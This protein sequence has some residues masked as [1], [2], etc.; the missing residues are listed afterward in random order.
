[1]VSI[2]VA[3]FVAHS[4]S[5]GFEV[6]QRV[7]RD[8]SVTLGVKPTGMKSLREAMG[9][10][11][12]RVSQDVGS[13]APLVPVWNAIVGEVVARHTRPLTLSQGVLI[14]GCDAPAWRDALEPERHATLRKVQAQLGEAQVRSLVFQAP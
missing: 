12:G 11:L 5:K 13:A 14:I 9:P 7:N 6:L 2:G 3:H 4:F 1:M 8:I 10:M